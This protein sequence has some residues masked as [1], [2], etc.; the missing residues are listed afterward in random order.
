MVWKDKQNVNILN[1]ILLLLAEGNFYDKHRKFLT[2]HMG[3]V[4]RSDTMTKYYSII[5]KAMEMDEEAI[6]SPSLNYHY[7][8]FYHSHLLWLKIITPT[9]H[10]DN[11]EGECLK[12]IPQSKRDK[13][14]PSDVPCM[15]H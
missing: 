4:D 11:G 7:H 9:I 5:K 6:F 14:H 3:Y 15:F 8:Q 13:P 10:T 1:N 2:E 12:L